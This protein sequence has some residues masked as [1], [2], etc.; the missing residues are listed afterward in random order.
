[1]L[2]KILYLSN[3][4]YFRF[5]QNFVQ[6]Y[7]NYHGKSHIG[8]VLDSTINRVIKLCIFLVM[9]SFVFVS[10]STLADVSQ[11]D[12]A[13]AQ[14]SLNSA[15]SASSSTAAD[16]GRYLGCES[17]FAA[18]ALQ[19]NVPYSCMAQP[20]FSMAYTSLVTAGMS[21]GALMRLKMHQDQVTNVTGNCLP[22]NKA[23]Y[24]N[25]VLN[26]SWC[27][28]VLLIAN[29]GLSAFESIFSGS[30]PLP[31]I[32]TYMFDHSTGP[33]DLTFYGDVVFEVGA[34]AATVLVPS[35]MIGVPTLSP[36]LAFMYNVAV[37][38]DRI[39]VN[40]L[41]VTGA[42]SPLGCKYIEEP[43]PDAMIQANDCATIAEDSSQTPFPITSVIVSCIRQA[44]LTLVD[45]T[46]FSAPSGSVSNN[47]GG[48]SAVIL[49]NELGANK[50][51][52]IHAFQSS[53]QSAVTAFIIIYLA[54]LGGKIALT[55]EKI[56]NKDFI[57]AV[58]K[59]IFVT[60][61]SI[62]I[63]MSSGGGSER[64]D[65]MSTFLFPLML[66]GIT[67]IASWMMQGVSQ[68]NGL[69]QFPDTLYTTSLYDSNMSL[70]DQIDCR[71]SFYIGYDGF[72]EMLLKDVSNDPVNHQIPPYVFLAMPGLIL[73]DIPL[74]M[75]A[76]SY[77]IMIL[78]YVA[79]AICLFVSGMI[80]IVIIGMLAP[81][82]VPLMLFE[83]TQEYFDK[84]WKTLLGLVLQPAVAL[85]F[86]AIMFSV[87][88]RAFYGTCFFNSVDVTY[89]ASDGS[90]AKFRDFFISL[91]SD[92][93]SGQ[94]DIDTCTMSLGYFL[95]NPVRGLLG[96]VSNPAISTLG[97]AT[98]VSTNSTLSVSQED[99]AQIAAAK[100]TTE[101]G[102]LQG[103]NSPRFQWNNGLFT[104]S[105]KMFW[106]DL[107]NIIEN[108]I[109][110]FILLSV[111]KHLMTDITAFIMG[112]TGTDFVASP[113]GAGDIKKAITSGSS[114]ALSKLKKSSQQSS[115]NGGQEKKGNDSGGGGKAKS[116]RGKGGARGGKGGSGDSVMKSIKK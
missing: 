52:V 60:Y 109:M 30:S 116:A 53:M 29:N 104:Q 20:I 67:E 58:V 102:Y 25:P 76:L 89:E 38:Q 107:V 5:L 24:A 63:N 8:L 92:D 100:P 99:A 59:V 28:N 64:Y 101:S 33:M 108:L 6:K 88:D 49:A 110:C 90:Q 26:F 37:S 70:W 62:G 11:S 42:M 66:N 7:A 36:V 112:I 40:I 47:A 97:Q 2:Y 113:V 106:E 39:C 105:P 21:T 78:S 17:G 80:L 43:F 50:N 46:L 4:K 35:I 82:F 45:G 103:Q 93:Y 16:I 61:F 87:Y 86:M 85:A 77:P 84:W 32:N 54:W 9:L 27:S 65:G 91:N 79:Y 81:V 69:C 57:T 1:M 96:S 75:M 14:S 31:N 13:N 74:V 19:Y 115:Q 72:V 12:I 23:S 114:A 56:K 51:N 94:S 18:D 68:I 41:T 83:R 71:L 10:S 34:A 95:N 98:G 44:A 48:S 3:L 55:P 22:T 73:G 15:A 111:L